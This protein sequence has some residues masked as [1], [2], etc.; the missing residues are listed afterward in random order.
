M[1]ESL[2]LTYAVQAF[3]L[4]NTS[5]S[6]DET[7]TIAGQMTKYAGRIVELR[8]TAVRDALI[9]LGWTPPKEQ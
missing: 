3:I 5:F 2:E 8:D 4:S 7:H 6:V 9:E 1:A